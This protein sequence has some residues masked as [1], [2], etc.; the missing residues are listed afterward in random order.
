MG[1]RIQLTGFQWLLLGT[2]WALSLLVV[3]LRLRIRRRRL[4]LDLA[5]CAKDRRLR[6]LIADSSDL[7]L[8]VNPDGTI[9]YLSP[10]VGRVLGYDEKTLWSPSLLEFI[11]PDDLSGMRD[12]LRQAAEDVTGVALRGEFR[13]KGSKGEWIYVEGMIT[14]HLGENTIGGLLLNV[15]N[16]TERKS[17]ERKL[18]YQALH[19]PLT[20][21]A[22]RSLLL[23]EAEDTLRKAG[24]KDGFGPALMFLDL[25]DFKQ[26]NDTLGHGAGDRL[27]VEIARR[28][29]GT[30]REGDLVARLGGDEFAVLVRNLHGGEASIV[31][32]RLLSVL[33]EPYAMLGGRLQPSTSIGIALHT[34]GVSAEELLRRADVAMYAAKSAGKNDYRVFSP[35][36]D[37]LLKNRV[38]LEADLR[39]A[40]GDWWITIHYQPIVDLATRVVVGVEALLRWNHPKFGAL[41]AKDLLPAAERIGLAGEIGKKVLAEACAELASWRRFP[42]GDQMFLSVNVSASELSDADY[43][44]TAEECLRRTSLSPERLVLEV[45]PRAVLDRDDLVLERL[46]ALKALGIRLTVDGFGG[47]EVSLGVLKDVPWTYVKLGPEVTTAAA[48]EETGRLIGETVVGLCA[49]LSLQVIAGGIEEREDEELA[50]SLGCSMGQGRYFGHPLPAFDLRGLLFPLPLQDPAVREPHARL[51][52]G[53]EGSE[54]STPALKALL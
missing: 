15:R 48:R 22:N 12:L 17:L 8:V 54:A 38:E 27:L 18:A 21:L 44:E 29:E 30:C 4:T 19:D 1:G 37:A 45:D 5:S 10:S 41:S 35:K 23:K 53:G 43:L 26:V 49:R 2:A 34:D 25:D 31:A 7:M 9:R 33:C 6:A 20:G 13:L 24:R 52:S 50:R 51:H 11:H 3:Y 46:R 42:A 28:L 16:V 36:L 47:D 14:N 32:E 40:V 39:S